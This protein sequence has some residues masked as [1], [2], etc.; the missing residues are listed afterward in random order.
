M[1]FFHMANY[2]DSVFKNCLSSNKSLT[3]VSE[4]V[5]NKKPNLE[6]IYPPSTTNFIKPSG[7]PEIHQLQNFPLSYNTKQI[8]AIGGGSTLDTAK[9]LLARILVKDSISLRELCQSES[10]SNYTEISRSELDLI[11]IP[12]LFGSGA[13]TT[14]TATIWDEKNSAKLTLSHKYFSADN[15]IYDAS[16]PAIAKTEHQIFSTLDCL[17]HAVESCW[18]KDNLAKKSEKAFIAIDK[19][20]KSLLALSR[21]G[22]DVSTYSDLAIASRY[23]GE[24]ICVHPTSVAHSLSYPLSLKFN[25]PHGLASSVLL[26]ELLEI[27]D[28]QSLPV[29]RQ[30]KSSLAKYWQITSKSVREA[31]DEFYTLC[32]GSQYLTSFINCNVNAKQLTFDAMKYQKFY[33]SQLAISENSASELYNYLF[34]R[35]N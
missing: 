30:V 35:F 33:N 27:A 21:E 24:S 8:I 10:I 14:Q 31:Y 18:H 19:C 25:M 23:A 4:N 7:S 12:S 13:E 16:L 17:S 22:C 2:T 26:G 32:G 5:L 34:F 9:G 15:I 11:L 3:I 1:N 29:V 20:I 28:K 6:Y